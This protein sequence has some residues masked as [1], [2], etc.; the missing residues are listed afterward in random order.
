MNHLLRALAPISDAGWELLDE[1]ARDG[2]H[3]R[4][5]RASSSTSRARSAGSTRRP[6]SGARA[7]WL[8]AGRRRVA[9][10]QRRVLPLV[11]LRADFDVSR[12]ELRDAD[13]GADDVDLEPLDTAAHQIATAENAAVFHGWAG[14]ITGIAEASPHEQMRSARTPTATRAVAGAVERL[15]RQRHRR[16]VRAGARTRAVPPRRS[17]RRSTAATRCSSTCARS[18]TARS[19]GRRA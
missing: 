19:C 15:L 18:S 3:R 5:P 7:R 12:D 17:R 1:E 13:R 11:E 8:G 16:P 14:A 4:S 6:T 10:L 2:W 9:G